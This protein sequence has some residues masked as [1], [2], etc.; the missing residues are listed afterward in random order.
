MKFATMTSRTLLALIVLVC[1]TTLFAADDGDKLFVNL[2]TD[3]IDKAAMAINFSTNILTEKKIPVTIFLNVEGV[4]IA[5]KNIPEHKH[6]TGQS[7]KEMLNGFM[8]AGGQVL[9][10][11]M[12]MKNVGGMDQLELIDGVVVGGP[13]ITWPALFAE[14]TTVLSY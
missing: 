13:D 4:R 1:S 12:C 6:A 9:V 8:D 7:L 5:D 2:S 3:Q 10:C 11:P 14:G